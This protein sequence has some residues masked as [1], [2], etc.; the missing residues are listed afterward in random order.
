M[1][2]SEESNLGPRRRKQQETVLPTNA[3]LPAS[4]DTDNEYQIAPTPKG[5]SSKTT[6]VKGGRRLGSVDAPLGGDLALLACACCVALSCSPN[7]SEP[8]FPNSASVQNVRILENGLC[9]RE[10]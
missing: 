6:E 9:P 10:A 3:P 8:L 7:L 1:G 5:T 4:V 2:A